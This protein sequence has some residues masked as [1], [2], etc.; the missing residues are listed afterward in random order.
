[1][2]R[3]YRD[4]DEMGRTHP[5]MKRG[6]KPNMVRTQYTTPLWTTSI[7]AVADRRTN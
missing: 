3:A 7:A 5:C 1:M 4:L 6:E 2:L